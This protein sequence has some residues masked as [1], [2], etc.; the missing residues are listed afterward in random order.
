ML[1]FL[2]TFFNNKKLHKNSWKILTIF[3]KTV[4]DGLNPPLTSSQSVVEER[5]KDQ[6]GI[7]EN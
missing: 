6:V 1:E 5:R 2:N 3:R 7:L 4:E